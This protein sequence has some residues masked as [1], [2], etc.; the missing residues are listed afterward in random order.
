MTLP[1]FLNNLA[2]THVNFDDVLT[3]NARKQP[4]RSYN[5][6]NACKIASVR[7]GVFVNGNIYNSLSELKRTVIRGRWL[8]SLHWGVLLDIS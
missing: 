5:F 8:S 4:F 7:G 6:H 2:F 1:S 3:S